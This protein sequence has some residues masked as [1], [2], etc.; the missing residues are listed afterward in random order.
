MKKFKVVLVLVF[1]A[2]M[3]LLLF[4]SDSRKQPVLQ[5][6]AEGPIFYSTAPYY[7]RQLPDG[8]LYMRYL[9][10]GGVI[11][12]IIS[13][14]PPGTKFVGEIKEEKKENGNGRYRM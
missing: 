9:T 11:T 8:R 4:Q 5:E 13:A 12:D 10:P 3:M 2:V 6:S 1:W 7:K 14:Q